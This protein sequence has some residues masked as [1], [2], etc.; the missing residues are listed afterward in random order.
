MKFEDAVKIVQKHGYHLVRKS[1]SNKKVNESVISY[2]YI[3][4]QNCRLIIRNILKK[5]IKNAAEI[6]AILDKYNDK[7]IDCVCNPGVQKYEELS[8]AYTKLAYEIL[9]DE[10]IK[11]DNTLSP[12]D[13]LKEAKRIV[14]A[15]GLRFVKESKRY[16]GKHPVF[17]SKKFQDYLIKE[18]GI[19]CEDDKCCGTDHRECCDDQEVNICPD[20]GGEG[21]EHC[22][23]KGYIEWEDDPNNIPDNE[24]YND[25]DD[26]DIENDDVSFNYGP[27]ES[28]DL[29]DDMAM[30]NFNS[31]RRGRRPLY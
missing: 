7:I 3:E 26:F 28:E 15:N 19:N 13:K 16:A 24:V 4:G 22:N 20:C 12:E 2:F 14:T 29:V 5:Y 1:N 17:D 23:F 6:D 11:V 21:C 25:I 27:D 10:G 9:D 30:Q 31:L 18:C 8:D